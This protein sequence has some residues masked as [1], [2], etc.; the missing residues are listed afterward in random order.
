MDH[1][2]VDAKF[3]SLHPC[4]DHIL[5]R[6]RG[7]LGQNDITFHDRFIVQFLRIDTKPYKHVEKSDQFSFLSKMNMDAK[8]DQKTSFHC[9]QL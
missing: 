1:F 3:F 5:N 6:L 9:A 4:L 7:A 8:F 2:L